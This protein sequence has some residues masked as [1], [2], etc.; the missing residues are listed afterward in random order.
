MPYSKNQLL[1]ESW[2]E[3]SK[4][5]MKN[6][7]VE[8]I[9][10]IDAGQ[11]STS[12]LLGKK[13]GT[14]I[15]SGIGGP[16]AVPNSSETSPLMRAALNACVNEALGK[17]IPRP[18]RINAAYLSLTGGTDV[19]LEFLPSLIKIE[20][21]K[22]ESDSVAAL[23]SGTYGGPGIAVVAGTGSI[24]YAQNIRGART[25][26]GGLGYLLGDEG[27]GYW[28]GLQAIRAAIKAEDGRISR[29]R[30][31]DQVMVQLQTVDMRD[32]Q[33][34]IYNNLILRPEIARLAPLVMKAS[35]E[36]DQVAQSI[37]DQAACELFSLVK[38]ASIKAEF[39]TLE[40]KVVVIA[41]GLMHS[42]TP[43]YRK[44]VS[45]LNKHMP[46]YKILVPQFTPV[47]GAFILGLILSGTSINKEIIAR[48]L[49]TISNLPAS[50]LKA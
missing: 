41:G 34:K 45:L 12:C 27:S 21:I 38:A 18:E 40:E 35:D 7:E 44:F 15:S 37:V 43:L 14:L 3:Q 26:C 48:I 47:V 17:V 33:T 31:I 30:F 8:Y 39:T 29:T 28:M 5:N 25:I 20:K 42:D 19:A 13:D 24:V 22:A 23:A 1:K 49:E 46:S 6:R 10:A 32:A 2:P 4:D 11:T 16:G 36:G 9:L 50:H